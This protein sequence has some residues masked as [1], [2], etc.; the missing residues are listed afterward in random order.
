MPFDVVGVMRDRFELQNVIHWI[1]S[2]SIEKKYTGNYGMITDD[3]SIG[4]FKPIQSKRYVNDC[5]EYLF[6]FTK[7]GKI[8]I[9]RL[10]I[11]VPYLD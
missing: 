3:V 4:H 8:E 10:A 9:D 6:H 7:T 11:G 1:K 5:Q 2:I